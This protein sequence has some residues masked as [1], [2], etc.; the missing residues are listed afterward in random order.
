MSDNSTTYNKVLSK[1]L[2]NNLPGIEDGKLRFTT[3]TA[4]L[5]LDDNNQRI[6]F[7]DFVKDKTKDQILSIESPLPK[8]YLASDT[9]ELYCHDNDGWYSISSSGGSSTYAENAGTA[10]FA[11]QADYAT[12]A[13]TADEAHNST[14]AETANYAQGAGYAT[15]AASSE[16]AYFAENAGTA[17]SA[18]FADLAGKA[19]NADNADT[20][21]YAY[22]S[23]NAATADYVN[24]VAWGNVTDK[25]DT[26]PPSSHTH[27]TSVSVTSDPNQLNMIAGTRYKLNTGDT[28]FNFTTPPNPTYTTNMTTTND[29]NQLNMEANTRYKLNTGGTEFNFTTPPN[30]TYTTNMTTTNDPN[31]LNMEAGTKYKLSTGGTEFNFTTP[32]DNNTT[33]DNFSTASAGL[34]PKSSGIQDT[35]LR[36]DGQWA[37]P[38]GGGGSNVSVTADLTT[39][40]KIAT[41]TIDAATTALYAP[42]NDSVIQRP[43]TSGSGEILLSNG[44]TYGET[45]KYSDFN[46]N[47]TDKILTIKSPEGNDVDPQIYLWNKINIRD[48]AMMI[49]G[50]ND[51][52]IGSNYDSDENRYYKSWDGTNISLQKALR[53]ITHYGIDPPTGAIGRDGSVYFRVTE[54]NPTPQTE[55]IEIYFKVEGVWCK[56]N[57]EVES[58]YDFGELTEEP[59]GDVLLY[60][61]DFTE[62]MVDKVEGMTNIPGAGIED[63]SYTAEN[64]FRSDERGL[65]TESMYEATAPILQ[66]PVDLRYP[67]YRIEIEFGNFTMNYTDWSHSLISSYSN[68]SEWQDQYDAELEVFMLFYY[69]IEVHCFPSPALEYIPDATIIDTEDANYFSNSKFTL[70]TIAIP[71]PQSTVTDPSNY[72]Y[73]E[74]W[75]APIVSYDIAWEIYKDDQLVATTPGLINIDVN[76]TYDDIPMPNKAQIPM[77]GYWAPDPSSYF[78]GISFGLVANGEVIEIKSLKI[79]KENS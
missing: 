23:E 64:C 12:N 39:G 56:Y 63:F 58:D 1:G 41:M 8:L 16:Y 24:A 51:I 67:G 68:Q 66:I 15:N 25:P 38:S 31:Q 47:S 36:F 44:S 20:A 6:E 42:P 59:T 28:E 52:E 10:E 29:P 46:F 22:F 13:G 70:R 30:P 78:P 72:Q 7:T 4:R 62:S 55:V 14:Y 17:T 77:M 61:W 57:P 5:F 33:Y 75:C 69:G 27:A 53:D 3:D 19:E 34:V 45:R 35:F 11:Y 32:P 76:G 74:R 40:T 2:Q 26:F 60:D 18:R 48:Y 73:T 50:P 54:M 79:Y 21:S 43:I 37:V 9:H 71:T 49:I 65:Y